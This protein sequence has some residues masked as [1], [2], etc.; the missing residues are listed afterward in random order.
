MTAKL[1]GPGEI[2]A[3]ARDAGRKAAEDYRRGERIE[4][5][6]MNKG[7]LLARQAASEWHR[8]FAEVNGGNAARSWNP[9]AHPRV[10]AGGAGGGQFAPASGGSGTKDAKGGKGAH[11]KD[12][13]GTLSNAHPVGLGERGQRVHDLQERLNALGAHLA[14]DGIFGPKTLA[15]VR[16]FQKSHGLRVDGLVGPKTTAALREKAPAHPAKAHAKAPAHQAHPAKASRALAH[17]KVGHT[18]QGLWHDKNRQLPAYIQ[19]IANDLI[20][21]GMD[22]SRAIATAISQCKR[23]AA[24]GEHVHPDTR[25]KAA[26]AIAEWERLKAGTHAKRSAPLASSTSGGGHDEDGLDGSWDG[27]LDDLPSM[28]GLDVGDFE[29]VDQAEGDTAGHAGASRAAKLGTGARFA[30]LKAALAAK[31]ASDPGA[32]AAYIGKKKYGKSRFASL[33]AKA[34]KHKGGGMTRSELLR[35][36]P[37]E[38]IH[39]LTRAEGDGS[40]TVVEAYATVFDEAAEIVDQHG[41]Y[42]EVIDRTAFDD[43]LRRIS[44]SSRGFASAVKVLYNHGKT[45]EGLPAPEYQVPLGVPVDIRPEARGLLTRTAYDPADPFAERILSKVKSGAITAQSFVGGIMRSSPELQGP[46]DRYRRRGGQLTTVRRMVLGLREY[47]PVLFP[48]YTGAEILGVRMSIP[49]LTGD[50][51]EVARDEPDTP[52]V[53][54]YAPD[55]EGDGTGG[56]PG[57]VTSPR[58][59]HHQLLELRTAEMR[60]EAGMDRVRSPW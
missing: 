22:E 6:D 20:Q 35:F 47:G 14:V 56:T 38:D 42:M 44:R 26:A 48:A 41:H 36:Y 52:E 59:H 24:G 49:G 40:G 50:E 27:P 19:H 32:L 17:E 2:P 51:E 34:R 10:A 53:E 23:W 18:G 58:Y 57:D 4:P 13:R 46:G 3:L 25:A 7:P 30:K 21:G 39:I 43:V 8:G 29:A 54:E 37:L 5:P 11:G 1:P 15:A 16:A 33:A 28:T 12:T 31:G 55:M 60:R 9:D 45:M